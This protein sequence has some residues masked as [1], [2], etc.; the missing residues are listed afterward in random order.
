[1]ASVELRNWE[2]GDLVVVGLCGQLDAVNIDEFVA[3]LS[4]VTGSGRRIVIDLAG[5][6]FIDCGAVAGLRRVR[7]L[8]LRAGGDLS[9][10]AAAG[11]VLRLLTLI[12][13]ADLVPVYASVAVAVL[14][15]SMCG[16]LWP[17]SASS[18]SAR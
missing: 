18:A 1:M 17:S 7:E 12:S 10:A 2:C 9:L 13:A 16:R 14:P 5:L 3:S 11:I 4:A 8:A 6:G 15:T